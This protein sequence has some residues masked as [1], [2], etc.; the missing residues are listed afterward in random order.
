MELSE[1]IQTR[2]S[3]RAFL[4]KEIDKG[5]LE[6]VLEAANRSP[7]YMNSQ[8]WELF[9]IAGDKKAAL[10]QRLFE[11][12][13]SEIAPAPDFPFVKEW[14]KALER[15]VKKTRLE[16][17]KAV[18]IDPKDKEG[19]RKSYLKNF[20]FFNAPCAIFVGMERGLTSWSVLDL[21]LFVHG[22]LLCLV[23]EGLGCCPQ[24]MPAAYPDIIREELEIPDTF[25][26]VLAISIGYPDPDA[27]INRYRTT[28]RDLDEFVRWYDL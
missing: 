1:C 5:I 23:A 12:A 21:G 10:S 18:G 15:R 17:F 9:V 16:R 24:A 14:P 8:P 25:S 19:I 3:C 20:R 7:S 26:L 22:L 2:K 4:P 13:S 27:P 6:K 11:Q 28:R